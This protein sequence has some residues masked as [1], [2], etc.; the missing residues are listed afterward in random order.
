M[1]RKSKTHTQA[2]DDLVNIKSKMCTNPELSDRFISDV[3]K[4]TGYEIDSEG[5]IVDA[6]ENPIEPEYMVIK[7]KFLRNSTGGILHRNDMIFDPYNNIGIMEELF[8]KYLA[9]NHPEVS[10]TQI[11]MYDNKQQPRP[12]KYGYMTVIYGNGAS[13]KTSLHWK[14]TTKYLDAFMRLESMTDEIINDILKPYDDY[15]N[16][17]YRELERL[18]RA[19]GYRAN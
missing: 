13:I 9:E 11:L 19:N 12:D 2:I 5:Y 16:V 14:D 6:E 17:Y 7:G 3:L 1:P 10:S 18:E 4:I 15:E 8:K